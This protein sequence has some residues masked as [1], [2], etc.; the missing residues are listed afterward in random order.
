[1]TFFYLQ[2]GIIADR[3]LQAFTVEISEYADTHLIPFVPATGDTVQLE[4]SMLSPFHR[5]NLTPLSQTANSTIFGAS[6]KTPDQHGIF[7]FHIKYNRPFLTNIEEKR[8]VTVRHFAHDEWPR[9]WQISGA[10][11][12]IGGIWITVIGWLAFVALWLYS[13]PTEKSIKKTQ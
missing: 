9:S 7:N 3:I 8:Q 6:F 4:F 2:L 1:V 11:V 13:A 12:W 5:I 10:W